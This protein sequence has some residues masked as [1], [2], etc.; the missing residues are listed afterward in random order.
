MDLLKD[1]NDEQK[2]AVTT[3]DE[4]TIILAGAGSGKTK[5]ITCKIAYLIK[6]KDIFPNRIIACTFTKRASK[7]MIHRLSKMKIAGAKNVK[8]GTIHSIAY[9]IYKEGMLYRD[10]SFVMP[11]ILLSPD[12]FKKHTFKLF[13][14]KNFN[15]KSFY[16]YF[17]V[18]SQ[19]K[20][21]LITP[22]KYKEEFLKD[23]ES[24][25][26]DFDFGV[27]HVYKMYQELL[28]DYNMIDFADILVNCNKV[29]EE[30]EEF[31]EYYQSRID[32]IIID[33]TQDVNGVSFKIF[34]K[35]STKENKFTI[36]GDVRQ[37]IFC[38]Q[39]ASISNIID[40]NKKYKPKLIPLNMNYRCRNK[41]VECGNS[42][43]HN[44]KLPE[45][46]KTDSIAFKKDILPDHAVII[47]NR[48][49]TDEALDL[50]EKIQNLIESGE[51]NSSIA[52]LC[53]TYSS[54]MLIESAL[55]VYGIE[56][57]NVSDKSAFDSQEIKTVLNYLRLIVNKKAQFYVL[58]D[59]LNK[60]VRYFT[61][62]ESEKI[63]EEFGDSNEYLLKY[64]MEHMYPN[65][66]SSNPRSTFVNDIRW[67]NTFFVE[68]DD[69][70][71]EIIKGMLQRFNLLKYF[72]ENLKPDI[73]YNSSI[74]NL[75]I[76]S[77]QFKT[78]NELLKGIAN[79]KKE[80]KKK[81][82]KLAEDSEYNAVRIMSVHASKGL[83]FKHVFVTSVCDRFYP[84]YRESN[85]FH[86]DEASGEECKRLFYVAITRAIE[87]VYIS[88]ITHKYGRF[89][90]RPSTFLNYLPKIP[91]I[92][93]EL[94][95]KMSGSIYENIEESKKSKIKIRKGKGNKV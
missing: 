3:T 12:R 25:Y 78:V 76:F 64:V 33:E 31:R 58:K 67:L 1:L 77:K 26:I 22:K 50:S 56:F 48:E 73:D 65:D 40:F 51:K 62:N 19:L 28:S 86:S 59:I 75:L 70:P 89:D 49:N 45:E 83:E 91:I 37:T 46:F 90:V 30:D 94:M 32:H 81:R 60:P 69:N 34:E 47:A 44:T 80:E 68:K 5:S 13:K 16:D 24:K 11:D 29:L 7:E 72:S 35:L 74:D 14:E 15:N 6:E 36:V 55:R 84:F 79:I 53:R 52:L 27:Y 41:I 88:S 57:V 39:G 9:K 61:N 2:L 66:T 85:Y 21:N 20:L 87:H 10:N 38:F 71:H 63:E 4:N 92:Q 42:V 8:A 23:K 82:E 17:E 54:V 93:N 95:Y 43:I 18:I